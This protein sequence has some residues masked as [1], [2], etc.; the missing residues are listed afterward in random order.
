MGAVIVPAPS[1]EELLL[2]SS[3]GLTHM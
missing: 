1:S 2:P 3:W